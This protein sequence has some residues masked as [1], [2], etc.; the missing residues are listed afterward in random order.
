MI[1][2]PKKCIKCKKEDLPLEEFAYARSILDRR[3]K[4]FYFKIPIC[5]NCKKD[6][7]KYEKRV[8]YLKSKFFFFCI[9]CISTFP[10]YTW[11]I[12]IPRISPSLIIFTILTSIISGSLTVLLSVLHIIFYMKKYDRISN[13]IEINKDGS[14]LIKDP[15]YR[16][17]FEELSLL[18]EEDKEDELYNCPNCNTLILKDMEFC[19]VCGKDLTKIPKI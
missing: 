6:L 5:E 12:H 3:F 9:F 2:F 18:K 14:V 16:K 11:T 10:I 17:E 1:K 13:Y 7:M 4:V 19:H 8:K 15:E